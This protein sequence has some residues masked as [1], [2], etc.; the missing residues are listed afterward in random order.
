M[1]D[2]S[3]APPIFYGVM[4][5]FASLVLHE[6]GHWLL[7]SEK[8]VDA[9]VRLFKTPREVVDQDGKATTVYKW[10]LEAGREEHYDKLTP[11]EQLE[12]YLAGILLG[13]V[14]IVWAGTFHSAWYW[15]VLILYFS[16]LIPDF[17]NVW[18]TIKEIRNGS[19]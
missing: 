12:V 7:L 2:F 18:R 16:G 13:L 3:L 8:F 5:L 1:I 10:N 11:R 6:V 9:E 17:K 15:I 4:I 19:P 14:P